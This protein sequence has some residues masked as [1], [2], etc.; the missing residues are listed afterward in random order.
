MADEAIDYYAGVAAAAKLGTSRSTLNFWISENRQAP[1]AVLVSADPRKPDQPVWTEQTLAAWGQAQ[2]GEPVK[3][4]STAAAIAYTGFPQ[5]SFN[6]YRK[7]LP[8]PA[9]AWIHRS[10]DGEA[11]PAWTAATLNRWV[12]EVTHSIK[13][14]KP[15]SVC[16]YNPENA[17]GIVGL[18]HGE[19]LA[20]LEAHP[21]APDAVLI[22]PPGQAW[23]QETLERWATAYLSSSQEARA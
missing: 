5:Q 18:S 23:T 15:R 8:I 3:L 16:V 21:L 12:E 19:F 22:S 9:D 1:D 20:A 7:R 4:Y 13:R 10:A 17:A 14:R 6:S 11:K 2:V